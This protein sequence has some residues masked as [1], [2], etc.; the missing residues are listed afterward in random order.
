VSYPVIRKGDYVTPAKAGVSN[1]SGAVGVP[2]RA[3]D[4]GNGWGI[5]FFGVSKK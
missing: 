5:Y 4:S 1:T 3:V 2:K